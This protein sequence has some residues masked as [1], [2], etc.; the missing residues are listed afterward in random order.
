MRFVPCLSHLP[1]LNITRTVDALVK[2][3]EESLSVLSIELTPIHERLVT[4]RRQ[5]VAL[6]A[7]EGSHKAELKPLQEELRKIDSLSTII[8]STTPVAAA[9]SPQ[10]LIAGAPHRK[11]VDGKFLGPGGMVP[12]SQA[13]CS[14]LL[15]ECFDIAQEIKAMEE[16]KNVASSLKPIYDRLTEIRCELE[17]FVLTHRWS[18]RETDLWNYSLSLQEIDKMRI[19]G[20]FVDS[21]GNRPQGQYVRCFDSI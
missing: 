20:K 13:I 19:D 8:R 10:T 6:A 18:L 17:S 7:K 12:A 14:S 3:L 11:R 2:S 5:L 1:R 4:I 9:L 16:S 15:E 21:E